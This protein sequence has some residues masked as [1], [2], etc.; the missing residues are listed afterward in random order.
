M[1]EPDIQRCQK[2]LYGLLLPQAII[3]L[4]VWLLS[5]AWLENMALAFGGLSV[6]A[7]LLLPRDFLAAVSPR[8]IVVAL[9]GA[10]SVIAVLYF[11]KAYTLVIVWLGVAAILRLHF[12]RQVFKR[13]NATRLVEL[14]RRGILIS[15]WSHIS[16]LV[17]LLSP[18]GS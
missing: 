16:V 7:T 17:A 14:M 4:M 13:D 15:M 11:F 9:F 5:G 18:Y 2:T 10:A 8:Q 6:M 12:Q 3:G 1:P